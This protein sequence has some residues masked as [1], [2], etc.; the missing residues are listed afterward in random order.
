MYIIHSIKVSLMLKLFLIIPI[1]I[2]IFIITLVFGA[3]KAKRSGRKLSPRPQH[4][5]PEEQ[6][7]YAESLA[8]IIRCQTVSVEGSFDDTEFKKQREIFE[9]LFPAVHK[10]A[11]KMTFGDDCWI[12]KIKGRDE[13]RNIMLMSHHDVVAATG[14]WKHPGFCGEIH[15]DVLWGRGTVDTKTPLF[16]EF[17][18]IEELLAEGFIPETNL[19]IGSS[20]NE[21]IGGDGIP[22]ALEYFKENGIEFEAILDEGG[23]IIPPPLAGIKCNCA[24]LAVHEKGRCTLELVAKDGGG[25]KGLVASSST[26]VTRMSAFITE[27]NSKNIF[28]RRLHPQVK[29][30]FTHLA[31]YCPFAMRMIFGNLGIFEKLLIKIIPKLNAQAA[32]MLGTTGTFNEISTNKAE[33]TCNSKIFLRCV[34]DKDLAKDIA[35]IKEVAEKHGIEVKE[36]ADSFY[37]RPADMSLEQFSY[38]KSCIASVFPDVAVSPYI[39]PAGTDARHLCEICPCVIRFAPIEMNNQQFASVHSENE[40]ISLESIANSVVFYKKFVKEYR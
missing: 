26:P 40:N 39:L 30:M 10:S 31:P 9:K 35:K 7:A 28:I 24:M 20:H 17:Q 34:D 23:A 13:S 25:H 8:K 1:L 4:K 37:Y 3:V 29:A 15:G 21:E 19:Y 5:T 32:S 27:I 38:T 36:T 14:E 2:A 11:E 6:K 18:A 12:F 16:A 33:K 22:L